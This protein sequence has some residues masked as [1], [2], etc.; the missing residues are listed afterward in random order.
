[1]RGVYMFNNMIKNIKK[2]GH[3]IADTTIIAKDAVVEAATVENIKKAGQ[4]VVEAVTVENAKTVATY[5]S[6]VKG[7]QEIKE[8]KKIKTESE[9]LI[10]DSKSSMESIKY[11]TNKKLQSY[12]ETKI[13]VVTKTVSVFIEYLKSLQQKNKGNEYKALFSIDIK[14]EDVKILEDLCISNADLAKGVL[15]SAA[16]GVLALCGTGSA[17]V[18]SVAAFATASTGTAISSL[19]GIAAQNAIYAWLGGGSLASGGGGVATGG[20]VFAGITFSALAGAALL[21]GGILL[22]SHGS[23]ALTEATRYKADVEK[24]VA[25]MKKMEVVLNGI[26]NRVD[27]LKDLLIELEKRAL[28]ELSE[29]HSILNDFNMT[30]TNHLRIFQQAGLMVKAIGEI[31]NTPIINYEGETTEISAILINKIRTILKT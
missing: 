22:S 6:G 19:S 21:T 9:S 10:N 29:L 25:D 26:Q 1:M 4:T 13:A 7:Y 5:A 16:V 30:N 18:G 2:A 8:A 23:K 24:A 17:V 11:E 27:E 31:A 15:G 20:M 3:A 12:A 14:Q 28:I